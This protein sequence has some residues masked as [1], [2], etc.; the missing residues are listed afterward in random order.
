MQCNLDQVTWVTQA[1][2]ALLLSLTI[3]HLRIYFIIYLII[4]PYL[5]NTFPYKLTIKIVS[6]FFG[7]K[8]GR[9]QVAGGR[10]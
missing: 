5:F 1:I 7:N 10:W 8:I 3:I 9:W 4:H 6:F 2:L